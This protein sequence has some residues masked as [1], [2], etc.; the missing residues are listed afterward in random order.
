MGLGV[1]RFDDAFIAFYTGDVHT[2]SRRF[3][4]ALADFRRVGDRR[5]E[6]FCLINLG[7]CFERERNYDLS[8]KYLHEAVALT[9]VIHDQHS[10]INGIVAI[11]NMLAQIGQ[12]DA[13][14]SYLQQAAEKNCALAN[15]LNIVGWSTAVAYL[16]QRQNRALE[17]AKQIQEGLTIAR[18]IGNY[19][20]EI[21]ILPL[22]GHIHYALSN[23][24][25]AR[26][27]YERAITMSAQADDH[28][29]TVEPMAGLAKLFLDKGE[30]A[31]SL[32][33]VNEILKIID[34]DGLIGV[35]EP[36]FVYLVCYQ[37]LAANRDPRT[38]EVLSRGHHL[39]QNVAALFEDETHRISFLENVPVHRELNQLRLESKIDES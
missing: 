32:A 2:A 21:E 15:R 37:V 14:E 17:A 23:V 35:T 33:Y 38:S 18:E 1:A 10:E 4:A 6:C 12:Y 16:Y 13:A 39:L 3:E 22:L 20:L 8:L 9:Q 28:P 31:S 25:A 29:R 24:S 34:T 30:N 19:E 5:F 7:I 26:E 27:T 36:F 11:G